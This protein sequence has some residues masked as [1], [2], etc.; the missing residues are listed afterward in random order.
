PPRMTNHPRSPSRTCV[1]SLPL[2]TE[3]CVPVHS[4]TLPIMSATPCAVFPCGDEPTGRA[5][6]V[7][8]L[9]RPSS[10]LSPQGKTRDGSPPRAAYSH[11]SSVGSRYETPSRCERQSAKARASSSETFETGNCSSP[12]F[13]C[14]P[15]QTPGGG[16]W[17]V[18]LTN[19]AYSA[20]VTSVRSM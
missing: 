7:P 17:L 6:P 12:C 2:Y 1:L 16:A 13:G 11:S 10:H 8:R 5:A 9:A 3:A 15:S 20:L 18:A 14:R 19:S 4:Q